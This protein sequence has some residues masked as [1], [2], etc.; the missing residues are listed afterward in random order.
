MGKKLVGGL[1]AGLLG[2]GLYAAYQKMDENRKHQLKRGLREKT[3]EL[4]DRAVDYAFYANDAV[5]DFRD[6][7]KDEF[8][9]TK[10]HVREASDDLAGKAKSFKS[11]KNEDKDVR[12]P[13]QDDI[14]VDARDAF[15]DADYSK[16][17][18]T[19]KSEQQSNTSSTKAD[20]SAETSQPN[21]T[22]SKSTES[23]SDDHTSN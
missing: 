8:H 7:F 5:S 17:T 6:A 10:D 4:K 11:G 3:D 20:Q 18:S 1:F 16:A 12:T 9:H 14:I 13:A 23:D 21:S 15:G 22:D 2:A 19:E